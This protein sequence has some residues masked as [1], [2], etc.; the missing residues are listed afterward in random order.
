MQLDSAF[1]DALGVSQYLYAVL[2]PGKY[3]LVV[4]ALSAEYVIVFDADG[5]PRIKY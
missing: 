5:S 2:I 3:I 4:Y 1:P